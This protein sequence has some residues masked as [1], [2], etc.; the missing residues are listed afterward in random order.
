MNLFLY[1]VLV[2]IFGIVTAKVFGGLFSLGISVAIIRNAVETSLRLLGN[3]AIDMAYIK[4]LKQKT[5]IESGESKRNIDALCSIQEKELDRWKSQALQ[6][7]KT[8]LSDRY[9]FMADFN[10][11]E[12]A[13]EK[14]DEIYKT[15]N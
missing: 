1:S 13:M 4:Q 11:W 7:I 14:L 15:N 3:A 6:N 9:K 5:L 8:T 2:F 10:D 12:Q